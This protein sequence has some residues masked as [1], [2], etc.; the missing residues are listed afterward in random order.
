M[1]AEEAEAII[2]RTLDGHFFT[3]V[4]S[5]EGIAA[6]R[7]MHEKVEPDFIP[8]YHLMADET[9]VAQEFSKLGAD[10]KHRPWTDEETK[11]LI[12]LRQAGTRWDY[13]ARELRRCN[14]SIKERYATLA[15][16]LSLAPPVSK[17]GRFSAL[18]DEQKQDVVRLR[19][20]GT[21]FGEI[22]RTLGLKDY[23]IRDYYNRHMKSLREKR[24]RIA[25]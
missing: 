16:E 23:M 10:K 5:R 7:V 24:G 11:Q 22:G 1:K 8:A 18:T 3:M 6:P 13:I 4:F 14:R 17:A 21:S 9:E 19:N 2:R 15:A 20:A 12:V 25:A